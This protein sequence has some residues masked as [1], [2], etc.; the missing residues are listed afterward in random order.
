MITL[1]KNNC[2]ERLTNFI[3]DLVFNLGCRLEI[4]VWR[5]SLLECLH[6]RFLGEIGQSH[7]SDNDVGFDLFGDPPEV[8]ANKLPMA[9]VVGAGDQYIASRHVSPELGENLNLSGVILSGVVHIADWPIEQPLKTALQ[10]LV[11]ES[12][13][14]EGLQVALN[15]K[16]HNVKVLLSERHV[17]DVVTLVDRAVLICLQLKYR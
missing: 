16:H 14:G 5:G 2:S 1:I 10:V 6:N 7:S 13:K 8:H 12:V 4:R 9:I 17:V 3:I 11:A 15:G